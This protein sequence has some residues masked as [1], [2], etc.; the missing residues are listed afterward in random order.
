[1]N[2]MNEKTTLSGI[3]FGRSLRPKAVAGWAVACLG[4]LASHGQV[5]GADAEGTTATP[6][7]SA[8]AVPSGVGEMENLDNKHKLAIGDA[9]SFRIV[10][11]LEDPK[12]LVVTDSGD[13][14]VQY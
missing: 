1:M 14:E 12:P 6:P 13:L 9:L 7:P 2:K 5:S 11:D 10:E 8:A 3:G 4:L